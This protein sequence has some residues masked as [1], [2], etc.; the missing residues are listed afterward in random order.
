MHRL[1]PLTKKDTITDTN[2]TMTLKSGPGK[3]KDSGM[4]KKGKKNKGASDAK[5]TINKNTRPLNSYMAF[6]S[7]K[8][9]SVLTKAR[10]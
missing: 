10:Y 4:A 1:L 3:N 6:R 2:A 8:Y 5:T 7:E 9:P